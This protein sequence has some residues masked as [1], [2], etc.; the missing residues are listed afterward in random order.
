MAF[1][2]TAYDRP[3]EDCVLA[4]LQR[5]CARRTGGD[6]ALAH[7]HLAHDR[8]PL[9]GPDQ[10]LRLFQSCATPLG[11]GQWM[12]SWPMIGR[13]NRPLHRAGQRIVWITPAGSLAP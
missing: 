13:P 7:I 11:C 1:L 10:A 4:K 9:C 5:A 12:R 2:A 6:K 3:V 8:L